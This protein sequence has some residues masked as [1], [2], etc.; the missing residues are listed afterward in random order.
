MIEKRRYEPVSD[1]AGQKHI[2][3]SERRG[4]LSPSWL[5]EG[6]CGEGAGFCSIDAMGE[7][8]IGSGNEIDTDTG[9]NPCPCG[10]D[11]R[12]PQKDG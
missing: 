7:W 1:G 5:S 12:Q 2:L 11:E 9:V 6:G 3:L 4:G 10:I 8:Q